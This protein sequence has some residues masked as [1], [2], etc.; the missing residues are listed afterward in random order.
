MLRITLR[1]SASTALHL[2]AL[3]WFASEHAV[4]VAALCVCSSPRLHV[5]DFEQIVIYSCNLKIRDCH[6]SQVDFGCSRTV[7][8]VS[9]CSVASFIFAGCNDMLLCI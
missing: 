1:C 8:V 4:G 3:C 5:Y 9:Q 7:F 6:N 2:F